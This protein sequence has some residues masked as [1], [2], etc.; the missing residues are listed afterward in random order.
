MR[1]AC[2]HSQVALFSIPLAAAAPTPAQAKPQAAATVSRP[3]NIS[4]KPARVSE[5]RGDC[6]SFDMIDQFG[7]VVPRAEKEE[8]RREDDG[9]SLSDYIVINPQDYHEMKE[10]AKKEY[11]QKAKKGKAEDIDRMK[12][13]WERQY[14]EEKIKSGITERGALQRKS[15]I[16]AKRQ[17]LKDS[18][19][20]FMRWLKASCCTHRLHC[21]ICISTPTYIT[22]L[23]ISD[24][25]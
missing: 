12:E 6:S 20:F 7:N 3:T 17:E 1:T 13:E 10:K 23:Y 19:E 8:A 2:N 15:E 11:E 25:V 18:G 22:P 4:P 5:P 21:G 9:E 14:E 16:E 24:S